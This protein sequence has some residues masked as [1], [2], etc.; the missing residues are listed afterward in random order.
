MR[1]GLLLFS[2]MVSA[3]AGMAQHARV[4]K[5]TATLA[6]TSIARDVEDKYNAQQAPNP[7]A[8]IEKKRLRQ[9][10]E[11]SA[12]Y[13]PHKKQNVAYKTTAIPGPVVE[14]GFVADSFPGSPPDNDMAISK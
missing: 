2:F 8:N 14:K 7:D 12:K 11:Q 13:F 6:G 5:H 1:R 3:M 9:I 4:T 10:K